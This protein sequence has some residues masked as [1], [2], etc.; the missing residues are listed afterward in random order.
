MSPARQEDDNQGA[1]VKALRSI[2]AMVQ[3]VHTVGK[4]VP[5]LLVI[6]RGE[7]HLTEVKDGSKPKSARKLTDEQIKWHEEAKRNGYNVPIWESVEQAIEEVT[8]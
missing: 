1:I 2:G 6:Y 8:Q 7:I 3:P 5:D 4:G